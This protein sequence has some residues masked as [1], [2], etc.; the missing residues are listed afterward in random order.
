MSS[1]IHGHFFCSPFF[2][3]CWSVGGED[4]TDSRSFSHS[5]RGTK[6]CNSFVVVHTFVVGVLSQVI[7][8][9]IQFI[10]EYPKELIFV[11][12][13]PY[14]EVSHLLCHH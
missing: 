5:N 11:C 3:R 8:D 6:P 1:G 9:I 12:V 13:A 14:Y 7:A 2:A 10:R 4:T